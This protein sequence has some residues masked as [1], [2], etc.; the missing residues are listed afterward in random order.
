MVNLQTKTVVIIIILFHKIVFLSFF[1]LNKY[2]IYIILGTLL[3]VYVFKVK[4][5]KMQPCVYAIDVLCPHFPKT[6]VYEF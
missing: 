2:A 1:S 5:D 6:Y 3:A 4:L